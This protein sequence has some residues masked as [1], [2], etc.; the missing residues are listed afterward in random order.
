MEHEATVTQTSIASTRMNIRRLWQPAIASIGLLLLAGLGWNNYRLSQELATV[1]Q[2]LSTQIA[3]NKQ[4][5]LI[6]P[7]LVCSN[8]P[9]IGSSR[10]KVCQENRWG[11]VVW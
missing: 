7:S 10:L 3:D 1:K 4:S 9:T 5:K 6:N 8:N 2:D 11:W